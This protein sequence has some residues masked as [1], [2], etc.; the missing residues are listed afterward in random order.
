MKEYKLELIRETTGYVIRYKY[1]Q[2]VDYDNDIEALKEYVKELNS[3]SM[4]NIDWYIKDEEKGI[5]EE[6]IDTLD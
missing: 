2:V 6:I 3:K 1:Y 4:F 5:L